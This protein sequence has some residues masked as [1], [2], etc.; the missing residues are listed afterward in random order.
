MLHTL[1]SVGL[2]RPLIH[3]SRLAI[4][5]AISWPG[6]TLLWCVSAVDPETTWQGVTRLLLLARL[7]VRKGIADESTR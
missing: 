3:F 1:R 5:G 7:P 4:G 6:K 2:L